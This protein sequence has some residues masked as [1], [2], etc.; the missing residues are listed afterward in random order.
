MIAGLQLHLVKIEAPDHW[1]AT[2][3]KNVA[4]ETFAEGRI[5]EMTVEQARTLGDLDLEQQDFVQHQAV[6]Y[7][8]F[9]LNTEFGEPHEI[10]QMVELALHQQ[11]LTFTQHRIRPGQEF[12]IATL[13]QPGDNQP[14]RTADARLAESFPN[15]HRPRFEGE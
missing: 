12:D 4:F 2:N 6:Q 14:G 11:A 5:V 10:A 1:I 13:N 15:Q 8:G 7:R 3:R 9:A